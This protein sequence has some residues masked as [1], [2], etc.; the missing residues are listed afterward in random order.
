MKKTRAQRI[1]GIILSLAVIAFIA[2]FGVRY[3]VLIGNIITSSEARGEFVALYAT[4]ALRAGRR[5]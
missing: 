5:L 4:A 1:A 2:Y 3:R